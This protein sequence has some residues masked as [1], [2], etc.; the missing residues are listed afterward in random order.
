MTDQIL[1]V[2]HQATS[3]PGRIGQALTR[4]G[5]QLDIRRPVLGDPLPDTMAEHRGAVIFGGPMSAND[6]HDFIRRE[7]DW[8]GV[9][10]KEQAPFLGVCL[11][12]QMLIRH[13]GGEVRPHPDGCAEVGYYPLHPTDEGKALM[14]WPE[15]VYQWHREGMELP[16][17]VDLLARGD[18]FENQAVRVGPA[19]FGVQFHAELT[20][21]MMYRWTTRGAERMTMP[22]AQ[23]RRAHFEGRAVH[24]VH[25]LRWLENFLDLWIA[26]DPREAAEPLRAAAG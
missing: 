5:Y 12:A 24:D 11:G 21:A 4:R 8:I 2:L 1:I 3:S 20:L 19:A 14:E 26:S 18:L 9:P 16:S 22:G 17:G 23:G 13:M 10:L 6:E 7:T 15:T 25:I